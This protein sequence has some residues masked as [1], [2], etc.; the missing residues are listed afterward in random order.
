MA[1]K[2]FNVFNRKNTPQSEPIPGSG[3][4]PNSA[5]GYAWEMDPWKA[6]Q[7]F[8][9]LGSEG[10][11]F[12]TSEQKLTR[13]GAVNALACLAADGPRFVRTV[14]DISSAGRAYKNDPAIFALALAAA[15]D[16]AQTRQLALAALPQ[17]ARTGT[18]LFHFAEFVD[19]LRGW[20]RG[21][22]RAVARW[23]QA[24]SLDSLSYQ[25]AK[26]QSRDGWSHRDL[27]RLAHANPAS[28]QEKTLLG[29]AVGKEDVALEDLS[30]LV[31][32]LELL[33][34]AVG[35]EE[36]I[37]LIREY[38]APREVLPTEALNRPAIWEA[39]LPTLGLVAL[40]RNLGN[41]GKLGLLAEDAPAAGLVI[42]RLTDR[43]ALRKNRVH[44]LQVLAALVT[45]EQGHGM[46]GSG[47]WP[48]SKPVLAALNQA[49]TLSFEN[50]QPAGKRIYLALDVSG[51][52]GMG[53][54]AG[55][56]GVTPRV[57]SAALA[58]M[59]LA[60]E[61][62]VIIKGFSTELT[63]LNISKQDSLEAVVKKITGLPFAGTDCALPMLDA[64]KHNLK[65]DAFVIYT[66]S[67][68]WF[69]KIHPS[70]ALAQYRQQTGI[71][72]KLVVVGMTST[73]FSIAD[74]N[75]AG[76]LDVVGCST[77]TPSVIA[78]FIADRLGA[79]LPSEASA[80]S[81][82]SEEA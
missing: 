58:M 46:R 56:P 43:A 16:D 11:T 31:K 28:P 65:I 77:D 22:R 26:Y 78:D 67:E 81:E 44:P 12:Y 42:E 80:A 21:L 10:G 41:L 48:V 30:G 32:G 36:I 4:V 57:A 7:R 52:M 55:I 69:G 37:A 6:L 38:R 63:P 47:E 40:I 39:M 8:L 34:R 49:Y 82:A 74:P 66:D 27:L 70:Q 14:V 13:E 60:S 50:I 18:H 9:V 1:H 79:A 20:G 33:K 45:Y 64:L 19:G 72:A 17:V 61:K 75:D 68:T 29:W 53:L 62:Q 3:Q 76:M 25:L 59:S 2:L 24:R 71:S 51:S 15:S 5:G 35:D 23:Y 54:I 73:K